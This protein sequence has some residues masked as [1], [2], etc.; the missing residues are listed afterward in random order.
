MSEK[1]LKIG[2]AL[3][4]GGALGMGH[5][6][7]LEVL[8]EYG[9]HIDMIAGS[10]MGAIVGAA[11]ASGVS[12]KEMREFSEKV[13]TFDLLDVN[14]QSGSVLSGAS[15]EKWLKKIIKSSTFDE[16]NIPFACTACDLLNGELLVLD[17]G[18][19]LKSVRASMSVPAI[20]RPVEIDGRYLIDGGVICN[21]PA[22]I[23]KSMGADIVIS[24]NV[25]GDYRLEKKPTSAMVTLLDTL[26]LQQSILTKNSITK[27]NTDVY[28]DL[29]LGIRNQQ[30]FAK[31]HALKCINTARN[32]TEK[33]I[34]EIIKL[35]EKK[36]L[37]KKK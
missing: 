19:L 33:A 11:Y 10:S 14:F 25:L 9:I 21:I 24:V 32:A 13:K 36:S 34:P 35:I 30:T 2:L 23:V 6:G 31:E 18:D 8:E 26:F 16:L 7:V 37:S 28:I 15:A 17:K 20:F 3:G 22:D 5:V 12:T 1:K 29:N 27:E 4:G